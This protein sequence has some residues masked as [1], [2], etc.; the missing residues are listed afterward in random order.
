MRTLFQMHMA[1]AQILS[2][3]GREKPGQK[4]MSVAYHVERME[5][6]WRQLHP[7]SPALPSRL[8]KGIRSTAI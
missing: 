7:E 4:V 8:R 2:E 3:P 1:L 5:Y 6:F